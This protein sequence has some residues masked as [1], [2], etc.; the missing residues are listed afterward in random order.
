VA[1]DNQNLT[2]E[3]VGAILRAAWEIDQEQEFDGD[4]YRIV[5][6][7]A[8]TGARYA[9]VRRM[10][11]GDVQVSE[12]RLMVPGSYKGRGGNGGSD[13]IPVGDDVIEVLLPQSQGGGVETRCIS[14]LPFQGDHHRY[15]Q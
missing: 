15:S 11:A 5:V 6:C 9:Q 1:R 7:L 10:R 8:A 4:L 12:R 3:Q 13:P 2:D 14:C